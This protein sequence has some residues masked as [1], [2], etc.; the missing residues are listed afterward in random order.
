VVATYPTG[1][2]TAVVLRGGSYAYL[3]VKRIARDDDPYRVRQAA[4]ALDSFRP[5]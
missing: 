4:A 2:E 5:L 1:F 3:L